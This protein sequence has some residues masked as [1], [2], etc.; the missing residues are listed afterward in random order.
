MSVKEL[1]VDNWQ[2]IAGAAG[3]TVVLAWDKIKAG[4]KKIKM[5]SFKSKSVSV[6]YE[7]EDIKALAHLRA[8]AVAVKDE[9]LLKEI[10]SVAAKFFDIH[11]NDNNTNIS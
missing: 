2:A 7:Q 10:K 3:I 5:P 9:E 6:N 1:L 11:S 8:R 4:V